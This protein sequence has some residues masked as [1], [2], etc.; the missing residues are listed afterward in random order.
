MFH[1]FGDPKNIPRP[2]PSPNHER[3]EERA[4]EERHLAAT[5]GSM[6]CF[7]GEC[8]YGLF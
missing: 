1:V 8:Q 3:R 6:W 2:K 4:I 7:L 5:P